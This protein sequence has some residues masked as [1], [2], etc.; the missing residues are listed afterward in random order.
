MDTAGS[1]QPIPAGGFLHRPESRPS[2]HPGEHGREVTRLER[3]ARLPLGRHKGRVAVDLAARS[4]QGKTAASAMASTSYATQFRR[5]A[6]LDLEVDFLLID[7]PT[8]YNAIIGRPILYRVKAVERVKQGK[9]GLHVGLSVVLAPFIFGST[10]LSLQRDRDPPQQPVHAHP[11]SPDRPQSTGRLRIRPRESARPY[12]DIR[13]SPSGPADSP[14][15]WLGQHR[16][17]LSP[18]GAATLSFPL[19]GP[20]DLL[21]AS[22]NVSDT[23]RQAPPDAGTL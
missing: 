17:Q 23:E 7:V 20:R 8:A 2:F 21:A 12:G 14:A 16:S 3:S 15:P 11:R 6:W 4:A 5:T 18:A 13:G 1:A 19:R 9:G 22:H 10:S